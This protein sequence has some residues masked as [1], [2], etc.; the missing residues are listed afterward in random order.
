M[1]Y[2]V[3]FLLFPR[4]RY[5]VVLAIDATEIAV[6]EEDV[7]RTICPRQTRLFA[8][9]GGVA[10]NDGQTAGVTRGDLIFQTI[11]AAIFRADRAGT[12]KML[13]S[14]YSLFELI[15]RQEC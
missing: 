13:K 8:K 14:L 9:V 3:L 2:L 4:L 6:A 1:S 15:L 10:R 12:K 5:L 7:S 11:V